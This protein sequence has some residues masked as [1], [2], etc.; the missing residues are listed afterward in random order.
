VTSPVPLEFLT[1]ADQLPALVGT[2]S[3]VTHGELQARA[4]ELAEV[5]A[6]VGGP[7]VVR[8]RN[9]IGTV[10]A[11]LASL[12]SGIPTILIGY[13]Q[14][15]LYQQV[16]RR[17]LPSLELH[18]HKPG[19]DVDGDGTSVRRGVVIKCLDGGANCGVFETRLL[20]ATS[21][22]TGSPKFVRLSLRNL[23]SNANAIRSSLSLHEK[24]TAGLILPLEYCYGLSVLNSHLL[25]GAQ[26]V[27]TDLSVVDKRLWAM[28]AETRCTSIAGVPYTFETLKRLRLLSKLPSTLR[29]VTQAG[30][31]MGTALQKELFEEMKKRDGGYFTMYGQTE[32]TA[33][34]AVLP[35]GRF[36]EKLGSVGQAIPGGEFS[37]G[38]N[39]EVVYSGANVMLGYADSLDDL[40]APD[41]M[42]GTL[43]TGDLGRLD[44]EGFLF[45]TGR[46]KR[47]AK[48]FGLRVSLD[49]V[50]QKLA[51]FGHVM[52]V[53]DGDKI[54][55]LCETI[56]EDGMQLRSTLAQET[57]LN[58]SAFVVKI[59]E[60][61][62]RL[63]SGKP[64]YEGALQF[65]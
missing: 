53:S 43:R 16:L 20:L 38:A 63:A 8:C 52:A 59:V 13:D 27:I 42:Q 62:P 30:G 47:I 55:V 51:H 45:L 23:V 46:E 5:I 35:A 34:M 60:K 3:A 58:S 11:Y 19:V 48:V 36:E 15:A 24:E 39:N 9:D 64:D 22:S 21:G 18:S 44:D 32:A 7:V 61:L 49:D 4:H 17:Y 14:E 6:D 56:S 31:R 1:G 50:E 28:L 37:L 25:A 26:T 57:G 2:D 33:R 40:H 65:S 41:S 54:L 29:T 10:V 12:A